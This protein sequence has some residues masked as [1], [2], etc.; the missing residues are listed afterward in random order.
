MMGFHF[1]KRTSKRLHFSYWKLSHV[2]WPVFFLCAF[3]KLYIIL[4]ITT[5]LHSIG[6]VHRDVQSDNILLRTNGFFMSSY[7]MEGRV[8]TFT[9]RANHHLIVILIL[10]FQPEVL[11]RNVLYDPQICLSGFG[12]AKVINGQKQTN[13]VHGSYIAPEVCLSASAIEA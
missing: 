4:C 6:I 12:I 5:V 9:A 11:T 3:T 7:T 13:G 2:S 1:R 10:K 8:S